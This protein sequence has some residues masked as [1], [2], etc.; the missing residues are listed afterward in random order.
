MGKSFRYQ[1]DGLILTEFFWDK[2]PV[3][4]IQGP[5]G[6]GTSTACCHKMFR[7]AM[8]QKPDAQ[9]VRRSRWVI[10]RNTFDNLKQTTLKTWSYW[11]EEKAQGLFGEVKM[12]NP[13]QHDI[14][15]VMPDKTTLDAEFIFLALDKDEDVRKLLSMEMTGVWFNE[16][17][18][19]EK[20]IFDMA[21]SRAMQGRYPPLLD[22]G[23]TWK[24]VLCDLNAPPEGHWIPYMR[25][26]VPLPDE[27]DEEAA[28]EFDRPDNWKFFLQPP[29]LLEVIENGRVVGYEENNREN[30]KKREL[31]DI[32]LVAENQKW[33]PESYLEL[34]KGKSKSYIDTYVMNRVG[35]YREGRPVFESFRPEIHVSGEKIEYMEEWPLI[36]GLDFARNPA[37]VFIQV[38][39][40]IVYVL[41][42]FG[43]ENTTTGF[44]APRLKQFIARKFPLAFK[45]GIQFWGDPSGVK[46]SG[47]SDDT[48][49]KVMNSHGMA[50][51]PAPGN[52]VLSIRIEAVQS[53][54]DKMVNGRPGLIVS[55]NARVVKT[56]LSGLYHFGKV[57]GTSRF[58]E[59]PVKDRYSDF[60][61]ALQYACLGAGL[62]FTAIS[63]G[64]TKPKPIRMSKRQKFSLRDR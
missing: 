36:V 5:V 29:G 10:V 44:F 52:N 31:A 58:H 42:E 15:W 26:D 6:S 49:F 45:A 48:A 37:A 7:L 60:C 14:K 2:S 16:A 12:T 47:E 51:V 9:G 11:F 63:P 50:A 40:G 33:I 35:L 19:T 30:R 20:N 23:P 61:D 21:H 8:E 32:D 27:W 28:R 38:I 24:G 18:F 59:A 57:K 46:K 53:Q 62:G 41:D 4:I 22:G 55:P 25:G 34:I 3:S 17:Q 1:P 39:R 64:G 43:I 56:G 13:P 54:I